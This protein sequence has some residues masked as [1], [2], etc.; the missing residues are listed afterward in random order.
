[1]FRGERDWHV[2]AKAVI[3]TPSIYPLLLAA[4]QNSKHLHKLRCI[5]NS[6]AF[7]SIVGSWIEFE[8]T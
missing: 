4:L 8:F 2:H 5:I 3:A 7:K 6:A 1:M